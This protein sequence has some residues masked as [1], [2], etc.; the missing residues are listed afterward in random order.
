MFC[1]ACFFIDSHPQQVAPVIRDTSS[2]TNTRCNLP[3]VLRYPRHCHELEDFPR[4]ECCSYFPSKVAVASPCPKALLR[5]SAP[6]GHH[7]PT[8]LPLAKLLP[9]ALP[10]ELSIPLNKQCRRAS[11]R[12]RLS[13]VSS[14][15]RRSRAN[16]SVPTCR[17]LSSAGML[18]CAPLRTYRIVEC[19]PL[20]WSADRN[21]TGKCSLRQCAHAGAYSS[22]AMVSFCSY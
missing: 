11:L 2:R 17:T 8:H 1:E 18:R 21:L 3:R 4:A 9:C 13:G 12:Y 14:I 20:G 5:Y 6:G 16:A 19:R 10:G 22:D 7:G 15:E